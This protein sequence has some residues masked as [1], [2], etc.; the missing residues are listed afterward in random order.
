M[1][2][3][4]IRL[5][6]PIMAPDALIIQ[7]PTL[8]HQIDVFAG[9]KHD[10]YILINTNKSLE[11]IGLGHLLKDGGCPFADGPPRSPASPAAVWAW[12]W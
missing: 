11:A 5:R 4:A 2:D 8:L 1:D 12:T 7:D 9:L 6:E 10:G 3:R